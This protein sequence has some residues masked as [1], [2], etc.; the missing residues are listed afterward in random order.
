[1]PTGRT[2]GRE[3]N[4]RRRPIRCST[5]PIGTFIAPPRKSRGKARARSGKVETG[6]PS[7]RTRSVCAKI[8]LEQRDEI[9]IRFR[10]V[11]QEKAG[12]PVNVQAPGYV[13][14]PSLRSVA[15]P[16]VMMVMVVVMMVPAARRHD[17]D[18]RAVAVPVAV[19]MVMVPIAV[20]VMVMMVVIP[21]RHLHI[22]LV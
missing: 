18:A 11:I 1:M 15:I 8:M 10:I 20:V 17:I 12:R 16:V 5:A 6:F 14:T 7:R 19:M 9:T 22:V 4:G 13:V 3:R 21:L 2:S